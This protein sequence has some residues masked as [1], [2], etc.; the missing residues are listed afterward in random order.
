MARI[1]GFIEFIAAGTRQNCAGDFEYGFG[2]PKR[3]MKIG[4]DGVTHGHSE[5][6]V[7]PFIEGSVRD[8]R[9][10]DVAAM[11]NLVDDTFVLRLGN[12]KTF[13]LRNAAYVGDGKA[14]TADAVIPVRFEGLS[15]GE[16]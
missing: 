1:A 9:D 13:V 12:G 5:E 3:T 8:R 7:A 16:V 4:P 15:G 6:G 2:I 11:M 14:Q 10:L